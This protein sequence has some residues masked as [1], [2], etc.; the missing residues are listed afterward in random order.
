MRAVEIPRK[1]LPVRGAIAVGMLA[2][3]LGIGMTG[4]PALADGVYNAT[5]ASS[6]VLVMVS[7]PAIPVVTT[8]VDLTLPSAQSQVSSLDGDSA[9]AAY[10]YPGSDDAALPGTVTGLVASLLPFPVPSLPD[11]PTIQSAACPQTP[12][13]DVDGKVF[14]LLANCDDMSAQATASSGQ[15]P[16]ALAS[17]LP[18]VS[19]FYAA[20]T[21]S[22]KID[23]KTGTATATAHSE[24]TALSVGGGLLKIGPISSTA[25][26]SRTP[27]GTPQRSSSLELGQISIAG[28]TVE[29]GP[30]GLS[31]AGIPV[32]IPGVP[33]PATLLNKLLNSHGIKIKL[34]SA[35]KNKDGVVAPGL[36]IDA[37]EKDPQN[38]EPIDISLVLGE[39]TASVSTVGA[40]TTTPSTGVTTTTGTTSS[41]T[42]PSSSVPS[43]GTI[44][45]T[46]GTVPTGPSS[47]GTTGGDT[48]GVS[49]PSVAS[50]PGSTTPQTQ[51]ASESDLSLKGLSFY[52]IL[53]VAALALIAGGTLA[54]YIGVRLWSS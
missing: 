31:V 2:G 17:A 49:S 20:A 51:L 6:G 50:P 46:T 43:S 37:A 16:T 4:Q 33:P 41:S 18:S 42:S 44:G 5:A 34:L 24:V 12:S 40:G 15:P 14:R 8:P 54:R 32:T 23:P 30:S 26:V 25:T 48:G 3:A 36:E 52:P 21:A 22:S 38:G 7:S 47:I 27:G 1:G 13:A 53:V 29:L 39:A 19:G 10:P 9:F 35:Q 28:Q 11:I 45:G